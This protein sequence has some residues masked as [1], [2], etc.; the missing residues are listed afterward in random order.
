MANKNISIRL[1]DIIDQCK[2]MK[3]A[4]QKLGAT[5]QYLYRLTRKYGITKWRQKNRIHKDIKKVTKVCIECEE[6]FTV[7][8]GNNPTKFCSRKCHGSWLG[9]NYGFKVNKQNIITLKRINS[10]DKNII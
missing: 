7:E 1:F 6:V 2:T 5:E 3:E 10:N 8:A 4:A 9:K